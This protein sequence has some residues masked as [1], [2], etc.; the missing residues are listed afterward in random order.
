[1]RS[2][3]VA[4]GLRPRGDRRLHVDG[5][6]AGDARVVL[7]HADEVATEERGGSGERD[8]SPAPRCFPP[9]FDPLMRR[10]TL[11]GSR[12]PASH[13]SKAAGHPHP[14]DVRPVLDPEVDVVA[15]GRDR[16]DVGVADRDR[17][18]DRDARVVEEDREEDA[19][20]G[21]ARERREPSGDAALR[22][23]PRSNRRAAAW[24]KWTIE[25]RGVGL[26]DLDLPVGDLD[27]RR[28]PRRSGRRLEF[29]AML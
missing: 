15:V 26:G 7:E 21:V 3:R 28:T 8:D 5:D 19:A 6:D 16:E 1:M 27:P 12:A 25:E 13:L 9:P 22:R 20:L 14:G 2:D 24:A 23:P 10:R 18:A 4:L 17:I 29:I 11:L